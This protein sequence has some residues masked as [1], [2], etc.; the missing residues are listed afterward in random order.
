M[1]VKFYVEFLALATEFIFFV[2]IIGTYLINENEFL[3][4]RSLK[5]RAKVSGIIEKRRL[6]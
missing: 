4:L 6:S 1:D 5:D 3:K 2:L